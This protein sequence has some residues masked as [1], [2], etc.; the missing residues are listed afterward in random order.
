MSIGERIKKTRESKNISIEKFAELLNVNVDTVN[1]MEKSS[2]LP[3]SNILVLLPDVLNCSLDY[4]IK[5]KE[6]NATIEA[7]DTNRRIQYFIDVD[8]AEGFKKYKYAQ[9]KY[10]F[11]VKQLSFMHSRDG[12]LVRNRIYNEKKIN[13]FNACLDEFLK[14]DWKGQNRLGSNATPTL[15]VAES[16]DDYILMCC[17]SGRIDG[18]EYIDFKSRNASDSDRTLVYTNSS[19][20]YYYFDYSFDTLEKIYSDNEVS[21]KVKDYVFEVLFLRGKKNPFKVFTCFDSITYLYYKSKDFKILNRLVKEATEY[22]KE[23][24]DGI[25][26]YRCTKILN[27]AIAN[28]DYEWIYKVNELN[29]VFFEAY[30]IYR[31]NNDEWMRYNGKYFKYNGEDIINDEKMR[32]Y[33]IKS[34]PKTKPEEILKLDF[35]NGVLLDVGALLNYNAKKAIDANT[36]REA[37]KELDTT[38]A[39]TIFISPIYIYEYVLMCIDNKN[40][41]NF[42]K[43]Y[44]GR[45]YIFNEEIKPLIDEKKYKELKKLM[46]DELFLKNLYHH[47]ETISHVLSEI[48]DKESVELQFKNIS[49]KCEMPEDPSLKDFRTIKEEIIDNAKQALL[50]KLESFTHHNELVERFKL[51]NEKYSSDKLLKYLA[52][53]EEDI[54][55]VNLCS[56]LEIF[57]KAYYEF[58]GDFKS[59]LDQ[60]I[61]KKGLD[62]KDATL[63]NKIR[64]KRNSIVHSET[65]DVDVNGDDVTKAILLVEKFIKQRI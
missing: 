29:K 4:L 31:K 49:P 15:M 58:E 34:N 44:K 13:I 47:A 64:M 59:V 65:I 25:N 42:N 50:E 43:L 20:V 56:K 35:T 23:G 45:E 62:E 36:T 9:P 6:S 40:F 24:F 51:A 63:L 57:I 38:V 30:K 14:K 33:S 54:A 28:L 17:Y 53:G 27:E 11:S 5:G 7:M 19:D 52:L 22:Y 37:I 21:K 26:F 32:Y 1:K 61:V 41:E 60:F 8:D 55:I 39:K 48:M 46:A 10:L 18:L 16:I 3:P 2:S 12:L